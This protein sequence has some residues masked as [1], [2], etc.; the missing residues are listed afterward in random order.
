MIGSIDLGQ[1][2]VGYGVLDFPIFHQHDNLVGRYTTIKGINKNGPSYLVGKTHHTLEV[3]GI[4]ANGNR[5]I[6][7]FYGVMDQ[8]P[9]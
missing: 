9:L 5:I 3:G 1:I 2:F 8:M 4:S 6:N 7:E